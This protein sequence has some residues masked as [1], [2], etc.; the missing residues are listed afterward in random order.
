MDNRLRIFEQNPHPS[1][2]SD[3]FHVLSGNNIWNVIYW[4]EFFKEIQGINGEIVECGVGRGRSLII[5]AALNK[6]A[7]EL[8]CTDERKIFALDS[9]EGFPEP[10]L[11][12]RSPRN[13]KRGE[14]S[15]SPNN[16]FRYSPSTIQKVLSL[17]EI[18]SS[19][20]FVKGF[21]AETT[22]DL[23]VKTISIL[24]LDGD[25]YESVK[26]PLNNLWDK[27]SVGG[28]IVVDDYTFELSRDEKFP[29]ARAAVMEFLEKNSSF[30]Y[31][32]SFRGT[33]YLRRIN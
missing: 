13:P 14:W 25:L 20:E 30:E 9:F 28:L 7:S 10:T 4:W 15:T 21:F 2:V 19:V 27:V 12:D 32:R 11:K 1:G 5:L 8:N 23:D 33:P 16:E 17:A 31:L 29:G 22:A 6:L 18:E 3:Y 24:H 26:V